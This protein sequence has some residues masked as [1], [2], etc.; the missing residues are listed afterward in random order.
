M[1]M[2]DPAPL[3]R[4]AALSLDL[5]AYD[6]A[7]HAAEAVTDGRIAVVL[8]VSRRQVARW[9]SGVRVKATTADRCATRLGYHPVMIW[10]D[11]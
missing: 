7:H 5:P 11:Y 2:Y 8:G 9:A 1:A 3:V 6:P 10:P 4:L